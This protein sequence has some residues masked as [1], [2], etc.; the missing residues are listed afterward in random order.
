MSSLIPDE[1]V[2]ELSKQLE[3]LDFEHARSYS[4]ADAIREAS[5][6]T[7]QKIDGGWV[8]DDGDKMCALSAAALAA[9]A[10]HMID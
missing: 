7:R 2:D 6:I 5:S 3:E 10:R 9:K 8:S 1:K 4:L